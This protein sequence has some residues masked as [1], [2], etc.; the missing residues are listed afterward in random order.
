MGRIIGR[1]A[2]PLTAG[3]LRRR[4]HRRL[5]IDGLYADEELIASRLSPRFSI[6]ALTRMESEAH[7]HCVCVAK[8]V[9]R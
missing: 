2:L 9:D 3:S 6:E 1:F 7:L 5:T 8:K 4:L